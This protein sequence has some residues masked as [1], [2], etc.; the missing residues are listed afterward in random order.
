ME[1]LLLS[2]AWIAVMW[3]IELLKTRWVDQ[4][5]A[6]IGIAIFVAVAYYLRQNFLP[7]SIQQDI[8]LVVT[9]LVWTA[10]L[11]YDFITSISK[12]KE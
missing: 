9:S 12:K 5:H 6:T 7:S 10:K 1:S 2:I 8:M 11:V 3:L 4:K